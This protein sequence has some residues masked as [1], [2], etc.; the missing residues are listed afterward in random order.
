MRPAFCGDDIETRVAV[1]IGTEP[2]R[3]TQQVRRDAPPDA[4]QAYGTM[5]S[6]AGTQEGEP[7]ARAAV[8]ADDDP[9]TPLLSGNWCTRTTVYTHVVTSAG[10][11]RACCVTRDASILILYVFESGFIYMYM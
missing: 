6:S 5:S 11:C 7:H 4:A 1:I 2:L 9:R 10:V 3:D 8:A